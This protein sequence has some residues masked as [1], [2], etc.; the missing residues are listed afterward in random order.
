M[1]YALYNYALLSPSAPPTYD[2]L[3]LIRKLHGGQSEAGFILVH[4]A[5]VA[6]TP[7]MVKAVL[8]CLSCA[9]NDDVMGVR[10][11]L[12][13]LLT[14][15]VAINDVMETMWTR[16]APSDYLKLRTFIMGVKDQSMFP[17]GV[18]YEGVDDV[19]GD[20]TPRYYRGESGANDSIIP[21]CDSLLQLAFPDNPL[22]DILKD[23]RSYRPVNHTA[24][25][26]HVQQRADAIGFRSFASR[27]APTAVRYL[28]VLDRVRE[29][30]QRHWG[31]TKEYIIKRTRHPVAT[32]GSPITTWLPNQL[33][34]VLQAMEEVDG[35]VRERVG[36]G[37]VLGKKEQ[38][39]RG[40]ER[41]GL[42]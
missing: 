36:R 22:T 11:S 16:S 19:G 24:F 14:S 9:E 34:A 20:V 31:F 28:A 30:R 13:A 27:D 23:F 26:G 5:M 17:N 35:G 1:S 21:T 38:E 8:D 15:L 12:D 32:G 18:V 41:K 6:H 42:R 2:N 37:E 25:I 40:K 4:V 33:A 29:F 39:V 10:N 3:R 7:G